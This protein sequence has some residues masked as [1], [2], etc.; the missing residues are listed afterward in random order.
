MRISSSR[1]ICSPHRQDGNDKRLCCTLPVFPNVRNRKW[2]SKGFPYRLRRVLRRSLLRSAS[3]LSRLHRL[4]DGEDAFGK[5]LQGSKIR[6]KK[7]K[8]SSRSKLTSFCSILYH[9]Q[10]T[11]IITSFPTHSEF[12][13]R[14]TDGCSRS[15]DRAGIETF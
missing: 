1:F 5:V 2:F 3:L 8:R 10:R 15:T 4:Q 11:C 9:R 14:R 13:D 7:L 6:N 12:T